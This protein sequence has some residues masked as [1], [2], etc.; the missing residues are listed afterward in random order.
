MWLEVASFGLCLGASQSS[1]E[2][3][4]TVPYVHSD[5]TWSPRRPRPRGGSEGALSMCRLVIEDLQQSGR[6]L[7]VSL[8]SPDLCRFAI[9]SITVSISSPCHMTFVRRGYFSPCNKQ[10]SCEMQDA[11]TDSIIRGSPDCQAKVHTG[12]SETVATLNMSKQ[13]TNYYD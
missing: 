1:G 12:Q 8:A 11:G 5:D 7:D 6:C 3:D 2:A 9:A 10:V 4:D 13:E